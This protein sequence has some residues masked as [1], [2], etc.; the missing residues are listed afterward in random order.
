M[1]G[2]SIQKQVHRG[3][4]QGLRATGDGRLYSAMRRPSD[5]ELD[6]QT[7]AEADDYSQCDPTYFDIVALRTENKIY[8]QGGT[9]TGRVETVLLVSPLSEAPTITD[10]IAFMTDQA[11]VTDD[12][13]FHEINSVKKE[14]S[15]AG[16]VLLHKIVLKD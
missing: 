4:V 3:I 16:V 10:Y 1:S 11:S 6:P 13:V 2:T 5:T 14:L 7:P 12:T 15:P 8:D 9:F